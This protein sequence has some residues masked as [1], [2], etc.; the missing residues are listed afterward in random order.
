VTLVVEG[1]QPALLS[2]QE[3]ERQVALR[4]AAGDSPKEVAASLAQASG[5]PRRELYALALRARQEGGV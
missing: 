3:V 4:V 1:A 5:R 2:E